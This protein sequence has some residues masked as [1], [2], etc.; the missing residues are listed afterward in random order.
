MTREEQRELLADAEFLYTTIG[1]DAICGKL[2]LVLSRII[3]ALPVADSI[4]PPQPAP[5]PTCARYREA[6][7]DFAKQRTVSE[8]DQF[9]KDE[10]LDPDGADY[11]EAYDSIVRAARAALK[12]ADH[13]DHE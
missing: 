7:E 10:G 9:A 6:L 11:T 1:S 13:D 5:R 8:W 4:D 2:W 12:G 3:R